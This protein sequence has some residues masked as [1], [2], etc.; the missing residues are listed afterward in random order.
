[1]ARREVIGTVLAVDAPEAKRVWGWTPS[2]VEVAPDHLVVGDR[3]AQIRE[4]ASWPSA[5]APG[6]VSDVALVGE[7]AMVIGLSAVPAEQVRASI[8]RAL[9]R[10]QS[11]AREASRKGTV[12][13]ETERRIGDA[14]SLLDAIASGQ[15]RH[16]DVRVSGLYWS[17][18]A[19]GVRAAGSVAQR[20]ARERGMDL[21]SLRHSQSPSYHGALPGGRPVLRGLLLDQTQAAALFPFSDEDLLQ[22]GG[23]FVG[24]NERTGSPVLWDRWVPDV[25]HML[26][27]ADTGFGKT[28]TVKSLTSQERVLG[29]PCL[30]LDPSAKR[31]YQGWIDAHGGVYLS[32]E[33][34]GTHH[35]N[36]L[37]VLP[38]GD[39][40][41][42]GKTPEGVS[43]RPI[44]DRIAAAKPILAALVG[45]S[46]EQGAFDAVAE[47]AVQKVYRDA[48]FADSWAGC[49][50]SRKDALGGMVWEPRGTW[51]ILSDV[52][53]ALEAS[54]DPEGPRYARMLAPYCQGGSSDLLD[55]QTSVAIN[56]PVIGLGV[57]ALISVGGRFARAGYAAVIDFAAQ[58]FRA[59][60]DPRKVIVL[61]EAHNFLRD[62]AMSRWLERQLREARRAGIS[63]TLISQGIGDFLRSEAGRTIWQNSRGRLYLHQPAGDLTEAAQ[64]LGLDPAM[65]A[66]AA[67]LPTG[68]GLLQV[69]D[70]TVSVAI[71]APAALERILRS[72][73]AFTAQAQEKEG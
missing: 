61:D 41:A 37:E 67:H 50:A 13:A 64:V 65:L 40:V 39:A 14:L 53:R 45:E 63:M 3:S 66:E 48:S 46:L 28:Y 29:R 20:R 42:A 10:Q 17:D 71:Q 30:I 15:V 31:E 16:F 56:S 24:L 58:R 1:M 62:E 38:P 44:S 43:G 8:N 73:V 72:D 25:Q 70:R 35:L 6:S 52:R 51:P 9:P 21:V 54:E 68:H 5:V 12:D 59:L 60:P 36:P 55:G 19:E 4:V 49:F 23:V 26:F 47:A 18:G 11:A 7:A 27:T 33:P 57:N 34:A 2:G 69:G 22:D 32:L